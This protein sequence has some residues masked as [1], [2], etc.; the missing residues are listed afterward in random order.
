MATMVSDLVESIKVKSI[1]VA[2]AYF[3][4]GPVFLTVKG[5]VNDA[6]Q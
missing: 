2:D 6:N 3:A 4:T 1:F 5:I